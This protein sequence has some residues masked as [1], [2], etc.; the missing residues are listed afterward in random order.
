MAAEEPAVAAEEEVSSGTYSTNMRFADQTFE[1]VK[2]FLASK[3]ET[4]VPSYIPLDEIKAELTAITEAVNAG[5]PIDKKRL[6]YLLLCIRE[7]N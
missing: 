5:K 6:D 2:T 7:G 3:N 1:V 4:E